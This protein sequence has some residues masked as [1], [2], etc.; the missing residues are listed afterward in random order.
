MKTKGHLLW[1]IA[2]LAALALAGCAQQQL[3]MER[4]K[5]AGQP[6]SYQ[7]GYVD[8]YSSGM[9]TGGNPWYL[10]RKDVRRFNTDSDYAQGW[11]DGF[12]VGEG[13][14]NLWN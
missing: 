11:N 14:K 7:D 13:Y 1:I 5:L 9:K 3:Q 2:L 10:F 8:G 6:P 12:R 4:D